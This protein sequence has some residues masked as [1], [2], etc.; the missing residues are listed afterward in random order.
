[1]GTKKNLQKIPN[2]Y[3]EQDFIVRD[4][5]EVAENDVITENVYHLKRDVYLLKKIT[6]RPS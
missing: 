1:M 3:H 4:S 5:M 6:P 2:K